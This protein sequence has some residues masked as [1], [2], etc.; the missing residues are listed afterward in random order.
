M[1]PKSRESEMKRGVAGVTVGYA[2]FDRAT[3]TFAGQSHATMHV[4]SASVV[5]LLIALDYLW[6]RGT[7][8]TA[9]FPALGAMMRSSDDDAASDAAP[10]VPGLEIPGLDLVRPAMHTTGT[11]GAGDRSIVA[12][13]MPRPFGTL[14]GAPSNA[15]TAI[16][17]GLATSIDGA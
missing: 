5:K 7:P 9:G 2:A 14:F 8:A 10:T 17:G 16:T 6:D 11:V 15:L 1:S 13:F 12:V 4:R 3:N